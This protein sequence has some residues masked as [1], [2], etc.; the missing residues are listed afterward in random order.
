MPKTQGCA[1]CAFTLPSGH[2][3]GAVALRGRAFCYHH[4][5]S[6][7]RIAQDTLDVKLA[8][9]R[10][11]LDTMDLPRLLNALLEKLDRIHAIVPAYPEVQLIVTVASSRLAALLSDHFEDAP[12]ASPKADPPAILGHEELERFA[13]SQARNAAWVQTRGRA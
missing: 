11:E 4:D 1:I 6:P 9:Y 10:R 8:R 3:C 13:N 5:R 12:A 7:R 2:R